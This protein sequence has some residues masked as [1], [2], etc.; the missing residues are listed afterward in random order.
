[1]AGVTK[2]VREAVRATPEGEFVHSRDL[3]QKFGSR[4]AVDV[5]LHRLRDSESLVPVRRGLYFKGKKTRFGPTRPDPLRVG[6]EVAKSCGFTS[7]VGPAGFSAARALGLTTQVPSRYEIAVPG[8]PPADTAEVQFRSRSAV[9]R[10]DLRPMEVAV[11]ELLREWPRYSERPW[12]EF[13]KT[14]GDLVRRGEVDLEAVQ[15]AAH[16]ERHLSARDRTDQLVS[17]AGARPVVAR[18]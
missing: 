2:L 18:A 5:A 14:V 1:M 11:L 10:R 3:V 4:S 7:G 13:T 8:R 16:R 6:Y 9:A 15:L 12:R 17:V